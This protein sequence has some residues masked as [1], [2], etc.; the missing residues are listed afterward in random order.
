MLSSPYSFFYC[1]RAFEFLEQQ[2]EILSRR[3]DEPENRINRNSGNSKRPPSS[4]SPY[5]KIRVCLS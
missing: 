1:R 3:L 2:V 5:R 4:D